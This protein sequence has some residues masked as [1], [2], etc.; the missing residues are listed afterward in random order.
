MGGKLR[1]VGFLSEFF[2]GATAVPIAPARVQTRSVQPDPDC[3]GLV[4]DVSDL[5]PGS[6]NVISC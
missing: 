1:V 4:F 6:G 2:S 5:R 3:S